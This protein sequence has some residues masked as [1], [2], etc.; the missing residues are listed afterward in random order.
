M[1]ERWEVRQEGRSTEGK[2]KEGIGL[3]H[4]TPGN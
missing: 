3:F 2:E 4:L 1:R